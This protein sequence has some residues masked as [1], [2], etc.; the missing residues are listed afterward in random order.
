MAMDVR[1]HGY[2]HDALVRIV[3]RLE[4]EEITPE[5]L[6]ETQPIELFMASF[7]EVLSYQACLK[8][9]MMGLGLIDEGDRKIEIPQEL[10]E[11]LKLLLQRKAFEVFLRR[12]ITLIVWLRGARSFDR[13]GIINKIIEAANLPPDEACRVLREKVVAAKRN[14][15]L[16]PKLVRAIL[17]LGMKA[18][19]Y[20]KR[21]YGLSFP[22]KARP[23][24]YE[25]EEESEAYQPCLAFEIASS[26]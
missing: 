4:S 18:A 7:K 9:A 19:L 21:Y 14:K 1:V 10:P 26:F 5:L 11:G 8:E 16:R 17:I 24:A 20:W 22:E 2:P 6:C 23:E 12:L 3:K 13:T 15:R 25:A